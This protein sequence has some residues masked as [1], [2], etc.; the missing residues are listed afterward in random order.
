MP[1]SSLKPTL[2]TFSSLPLNHLPSPLG[3]EG[4]I[5]SSWTG[6]PSPPHCHICSQQIAGSLSGWQWRYGRQHAVQRQ[7]LRKEGQEAE[8]HT[9]VLDKFTLYLFYIRY[10]LLCHR[11]LSSGSGGWGQECENEILIVAVSWEGKELSLGLEG[12]QGGG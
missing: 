3:S 2:V 11:C 1:S 5:V 10:C 9:E 7:N 6:P 4:S 12:Q 8:P